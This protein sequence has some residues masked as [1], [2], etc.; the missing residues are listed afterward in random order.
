[1]TMALAMD[2]AAKKSEHG[3][4]RNRFRRKTRQLRILPMTPRTIKTPSAT[5]KYCWIRARVVITDIFLSDMHNNKFDLYK[6]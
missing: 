3:L 5:V 6:Y 4:D 1:M 2:A